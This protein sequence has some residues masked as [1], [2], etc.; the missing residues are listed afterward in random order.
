M[1]MIMHLTKH[2]FDSLRNEAKK[3][4]PNE[5][6]A[7]LFG[8]VTVGE[9]F[10]TRI[11]AAP[12]ILRSTMRFEIEPQ[13]ILQAFKEAE[14]LGVEFV[15]IFHSHPAAAEPSALDIQCMRLWGNA[16][17]LILS[18]TEGN[19]AAFQL[20]NGNVHKLELD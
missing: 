3:G 18:S 8:R 2:Q 12:N 19:F 17:W 16:V 1:I 4:S 15:G 20:V 11:V 6:C 7:M 14:E 13:K 9:A 10:V 5:A